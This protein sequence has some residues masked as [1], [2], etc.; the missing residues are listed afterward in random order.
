MAVSPED[1]SV[2]PALQRDGF[3]DPYGWKSCAITSCDATQASPH[4]LCLAEALLIPAVGLHG[5]CQR[6]HLGWDPRYCHDSNILSL[7]P[8]CQQAAAPSMLE[9]T[10]AQWALCRFLP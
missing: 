3:V 6:S 7:P 4:P 2:P 9:K 10:T 1:W 8:G 5:I